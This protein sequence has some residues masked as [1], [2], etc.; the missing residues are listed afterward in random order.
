LNNLHFEDT[1]AQN[2]LWGREMC[3]ACMHVRA[4]FTWHRGRLLWRCWRCASVTSKAK[5]A[6]SRRT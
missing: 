2:F 3:A 6:P 5:G 1:I 4:A